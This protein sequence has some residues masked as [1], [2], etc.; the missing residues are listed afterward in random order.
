MTG[1]G[2]MATETVT[3]SFWFRNGVRVALVA[4]LLH[5]GC[6]TYHVGPAGLYR[7]DIRTVYVP[8]FESDIL[9]QGMAEWL[10]EA[11]AKQI[12]M[13]T[14]FKVVGDPAADSVLTGRILENRKQV[15]IESPNDDARELGYSMVLVVSWYARNGELLMQR[16][17]AMG[18]HFF[19]ESGQSLTTAQQETIKQL[20]QQIAGAMEFTTW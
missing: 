8:M 16:R 1:I 11:V 4:V 3:A 17:I 20:A 18:D 10:T 15:L 9:R 13:Q 19:P 14:P 2:T 7:N 6:A 12:E 5:S